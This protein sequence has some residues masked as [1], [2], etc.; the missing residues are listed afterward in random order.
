MPPSEPNEQYCGS[1]PN[2][3]MRWAPMRTVAPGETYLLAQGHPTRADRARQRMAET[4]TAGTFGPCLR[5][6]LQNEYMH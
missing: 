2:H 3:T 5:L 4:E 1:C 6:A